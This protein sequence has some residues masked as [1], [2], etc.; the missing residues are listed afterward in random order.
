MY[1]ILIL[2][3]AIKDI[4]DLPKEYARLIA[5]HIDRLRENPRPLDVKKLRKAGGY[6]LRVGVYRIL[7]DIDDD[8][9]IV[10]IYRVKH[11]RE[12]YR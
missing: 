5:E 12:A 4:D 8:T 3:K 9:L 10:T 6:S 7:Y 11:R 2:R 1:R